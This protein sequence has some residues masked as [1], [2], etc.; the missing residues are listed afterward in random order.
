GVGRPVAVARV[1]LVRVVGLVGP[2]PG[3]VRAAERSFSVQLEVLGVLVERGLFPTGQVGVRGHPPVVGGM[4]M[5]IGVIQLLN[6]AVVVLQLLI[7]KG[8]GVLFVDL[9]RG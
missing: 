1:T 7:R 6:G 3:R 8:T 9:F 5:L 2:V 4:A